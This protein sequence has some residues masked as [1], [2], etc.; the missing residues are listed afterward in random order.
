MVM[1]WQTA[2]ASGGVAVP[3]PRPT[4]AAIILIRRLSRHALLSVSSTS[5]LLITTRD[6]WNIDIEK[7]RD[8]QMTVFSKPIFSNDQSIVSTDCAMYFQL[9]SANTAITSFVKFGQRLIVFK[10]ESEKHFQSNMELARIFCDR[11]RFVKTF[12]NCR[13]L[14]IPVSRCFGWR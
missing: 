11:K 14:D 9:F 10:R 4:T 2:S 12:C 1:F 7:Y 5:F 13:C 8:I 3:R 6:A